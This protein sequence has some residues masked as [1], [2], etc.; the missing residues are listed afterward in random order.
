MLT[1]YRDHIVFE[2]IVVVFFSIG[3]NFDGT[4]CVSKSKNQDINEAITS[5]NY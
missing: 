1:F 5:N 2:C 4:K 3:N